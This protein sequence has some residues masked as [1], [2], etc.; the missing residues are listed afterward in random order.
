MQ[1]EG[2]ISKHMCCTSAGWFKQMDTTVE[3]VLGSLGVNHVPSLV[4]SLWFVQFSSSASFD[5]TI[6]DKVGKEGR[7]RDAFMNMIPF[8]CGA[9]TF[10]WVFFLPQRV[11]MFHV[12]IFFLP[13]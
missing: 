11:C 10:L 8:K 1:L 4:V 12:F 2:K 7:A 13:L 5:S 3:G 9:V 6:S